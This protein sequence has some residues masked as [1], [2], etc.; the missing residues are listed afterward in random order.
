MGLK[1]GRN[2][3]AFRLLTVMFQHRRA[4]ILCRLQ[5]TNINKKHARTHAP[6][7]THTKIHNSTRRSK[8]IIA[9]THTKNTRFSSNPSSL[10]HFPLSALQVKTL[11]INHASNSRAGERSGGKTYRFTLFMFSRVTQFAHPAH[12]M[13]GEHTMCVL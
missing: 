12:C 11:H 10:E 9:G 3:L 2:T 7:H 5:Y 1:L 4:K 6:T 8:F 13:E